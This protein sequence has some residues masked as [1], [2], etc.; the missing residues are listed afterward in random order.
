MKMRL[1]KFLAKAGI[2]SRRTSEKLILNGKVKVNG[3]VITQL[4]T[5]VDPNKI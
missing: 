1:Q 2:A 4:G 5:K 3:N